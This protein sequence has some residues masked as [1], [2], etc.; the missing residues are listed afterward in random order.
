MGRLK[1]RKAGGA[2][3]QADPEDFENPPETPSRTYEKSAR[4]MPKR[5][6][7][8]HRQHQR[9]RKDDRKYCERPFTILLKPVYYQTLVL[10]T[11][12]RRACRFPATF[13]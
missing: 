9:G 6:A 1:Y 12:N 13:R 10:L 4:S 3:L 2:P 8:R 5:S 7:N 11:I